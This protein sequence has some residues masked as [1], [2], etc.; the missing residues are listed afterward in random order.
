M[1]LFHVTRH[2]NA[3]GVLAQR[4][5]DGHGTYLTDREWSGVWLSDQPLLD[6]GPFDGDPASGWTVL[7]VMLDLSDAELAR[8]EWV[9]DGKP[10]RE[11]LV[12]AAVLNQRGT[13]RRSEPAAS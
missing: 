7:E 10:Y 13:V 4:F 3:R 2:T 8:Y 6:G 5:R 1:R 12:P 11:W 9:E